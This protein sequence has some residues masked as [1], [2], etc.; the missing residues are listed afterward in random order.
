[1]T[2]NIL[3]ALRRTKCRSAMERLMTY[4]LWF[5]CLLMMLMMISCTPLEAPKIWYLSNIDLGDSMT[6]GQ[7]RTIDPVSGR[8]QTVIRAQSNDAEIGSAALSPDGLHLAYDEQDTTGSAIWL[9]NADGSNLQ[10]I[11]GGY[12]FMDFIWFDNQKIVTFG[13]DDIKKSPDEGE[14]ALYDLTS[15]KQWRP[16]HAGTLYTACT[17]SNVSTLSR[18]L[19][20]PGG[21]AHLEINGETIRAVTDVSV[22]AED[23]SARWSSC[24]GW[25]PD[26]QLLVM[27]VNLASHSEELFL[28]SNRGHTFRQLTH[29]EGK[30]RSTMFDYALSVSPNGKWAIG[31][32][33][34]NSPLE[35]GLPVGL[36][37]VLISTDGQT[38]EFLGDFGGG[39]E[40][41]WSPDSQY[42][43]TDIRTH[44][45]NPRQIVSQVNIIDV[46]TRKLRQLTSDE[47]AKD[48]F[49]WR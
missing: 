18:W 31:W 39:I 27:P 34:L 40:F 45:P 24:P 4:S 37:L 20:E 28:V 48:V 47:T 21:L 35:P 46:R 30:Y 6:N 26:G 8:E 11:S 19:P 1:M 41:P 5:S 29:F 43:A 22:K 49:D 12:R 13:V 33:R 9:A 2:T 36:Q 44:M 14:W 23:L 32:V 16:K 3:N 17:R 38:V 7:I 10:K 42:V 15:Q 25:T